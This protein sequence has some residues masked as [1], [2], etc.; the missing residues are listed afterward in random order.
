[1]R[2]LVDWVKN[3]AKR[4]VR[5]AVVM[6][7]TPSNNGARREFQGIVELIMAP[8]LHAKE[9]ITEKVV[10]TGSV[11]WTRADLVDNENTITAI[12]DRDL[13]EEQLSRW[14]DFAATGIASPGIAGAVSSANAAESAWATLPGATTLQ[15]RMVVD[16]IRSVVMPGGAVLL[17]RDLIEAV[18]A[19]RADATEELA[20]TLEEAAVG[21]PRMVGTVQPIVLDLIAYGHLPRAFTT[22]D[23][24]PSAGARSPRRPRRALGVSP[25]GRSAR[26]RRR[27]SSDSDHSC[28]A[29]G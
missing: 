18:E 23:L 4:G 3:A 16:M 19:A 14:Q 22:T 29:A 24:S 13:A 15:R 7:P 2:G 27:L 17:S 12:S 25:R 8:N 1:M 21:L 6:R 9:V 20:N 5:V 28:L 26:P 11:N 10:I